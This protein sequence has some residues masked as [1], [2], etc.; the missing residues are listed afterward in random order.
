MDVEW[1]AAPDIER[2]L[3]KQECKADRQQHL[4]QRIE[5]QGRRNT[6]SMTRPTKA[7]VTAATGIESSH[8]PVVQITDKCNVAAKQKVRAMGE[9]DDPHDAENQR[10]PA[11][12]KNRSA[13]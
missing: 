3:L 8:D 4:P 10:Q 5:A 1:I 9:I 11:A 2:R 12:H 7:T 6:R 13:P